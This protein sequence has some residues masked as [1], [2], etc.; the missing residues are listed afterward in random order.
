MTQNSYH[1]KQKQ[2]SL[3]DLKFWTTPFFPNYNN[4]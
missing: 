2:K 1:L 3:V 4:P